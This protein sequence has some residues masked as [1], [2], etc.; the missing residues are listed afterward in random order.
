MC[1]KFNHLKVEDLEERTDFFVLLDT[2]KKKTMAKVISQDT[3]DDVVK[4]NIVEF[5][6]SPDEAKEETIKQFE[7]QVGFF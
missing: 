7:A 2:N 5:E 4:E 6:M 1:G 3:F